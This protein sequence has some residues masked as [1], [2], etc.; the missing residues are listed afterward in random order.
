M[1]FSEFVAARLSLNIL[2]S[3]FVLRKNLAVRYKSF[4]DNIAA[5]FKFRLPTPSKINTRIEDRILADRTCSA[6]KVALHNID[7]FT[8]SSLTNVLDAHESNWGQLKA[9]ALI[10]FRKWWCTINKH[11][12]FEY[13]QI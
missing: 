6:T 2:H 12:K 5:P 7:T 13:N 1:R 3:S 4:W 9:G 8:T 10:A 11:S